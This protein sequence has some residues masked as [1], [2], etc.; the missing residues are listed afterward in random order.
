MF[1]F[2]R[3][4]NGLE[5][6]VPPLVVAILAGLTMRFIA[7]L[8]P[9]ASVDARALSWLSWGLAGLGLV[10][11]V[12]STLA[13]RQA[14]TTVD[15]RT[16]QASQVLIRSGVFALSRNPIYLAM[17]ML[18][19]AYAAKLGHPIAAVVVPVFMAYI[20]RFQIQPEERSLALVFGER[21]ADYCRRVGRWI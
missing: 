18:L 13:F 12:A 9:A 16:P 14:R 1:H 20:Q 4:A 11:A 17:A 21:Y 7:W 6:K 5:L 3:I 19:L 10:T 15:P 8:W 2:S